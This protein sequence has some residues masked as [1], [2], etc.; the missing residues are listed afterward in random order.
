[1]IQLRAFILVAGFMAYYADAAP[2]PLALLPF[3]SAELLDR[4]YRPDS[5]YRLA[6]GPYKKRDNRWQADVTQRIKGALIRE[7]YELPRGT[8]EQEAFGFYRQQVLSADPLATILYECAR[9]RCGDSN[10][11]AN[12]HFRIKQLYGLDH[13]QFYGVYQQGKRFISLYVVRR[14]NRRVYLHID[15]VLISE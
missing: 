12:D 13:N 1:M 4:E 6:L 15:Q 9:R 3:E 7:T 11:W 2:S 8:D 14:G 10:N 5:P